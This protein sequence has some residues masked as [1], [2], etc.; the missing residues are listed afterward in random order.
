MRRAN[1]DKGQE[2]GFTGMNDKVQTVGNRT[3]GR[4]AVRHHPAPCGEGPGQVMS[5]ASKTTLWDL[6]DPELAALAMAALYGM[7]A[8][9][10][11]EQM[12]DACVEAQRVRD[13][14]FWR[15]TL[16]AF[17]KAFPD[18]RPTVY[19]GHRFANS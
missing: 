9:R 11:I 16:D 1:V 10:Q 13:G 6:I 7:D 12:A 3:T 18:D 15:A 2:A 8:R 14:A 5:A 17:V 19:T 4:G